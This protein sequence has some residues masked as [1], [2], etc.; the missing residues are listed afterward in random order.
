MKEV[1]FDV[2]YRDDDDIVHVV[3]TVGKRR[4]GEITLR[5]AACGRDILGVSEPIAAGETVTCI[6]CIISEGDDS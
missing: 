5:W 1:D 6:E 4:N 3:A 2:K